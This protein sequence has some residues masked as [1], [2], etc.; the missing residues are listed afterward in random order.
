[1]TMQY[2]ESELRTRLEL[3]EDNGWEFKSVEFRG[4]QPSRDQRSTWAD[5]IVAFANAGGGVLLLGVT[6]EGTVPG[7]SRAQMDAVERIVGEI[8]RES[9][10]PE[11]HA[12]V[13]RTELDQS[14]FILVEIPEGYALHER[15]GRS[16]IR[17]GSAKRLMSPDDRM[18]LSQRRGQTRF[19][20]FDEQTVENTGFVTLVERL[21][22][23]LLSAES[24]SA[25]QVGL[26]KLGLLRTDEQG[27]TRATVAGVLLCTDE[28]DR[29]LPQATITAVCYRGTE[30]ASGQ[31]D[32]QE[33][34]G[35]IDRQIRNALA[36]ATR[37]MRVSARKMPAREDLPEYSRRAIF[38]ALVNAVAHRDYSIRGARIRLRMFSDRLELCSPGSLPNSLTVES[39]GERQS[40]RNEVLTSMLGRIDASGIDAA[41][42]RRFFLE[43][44]GDGV[45]IIRSE[46]LAL[47]GRP[48]AYRLIDGAELCLT[49]PAAEPESGPASVVVTVR[50][51]GT[52]LAGATVLALFPNNTWK[53]GSTNE[54]G[55]ARLDLHSVN[56][57]MTVFV[58]GPNAAAHVER[59]WLPSERPLAIELAALPDGGS[60]VF[61]EST[62]DV[63]GLTGR[64]NPILDTSNRTYLYAS[65]IAINGGQQQPVTF[66]PE[67]EELHLMD[68]NGRERLVRIVAIRGR[69]SLLE[70][71][72]VIAAA[73]NG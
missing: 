13:Y 56:L 2:N 25:P 70:Y 49:L 33:I 61:P 8:C 68:A 31:I 38:E 29:Y 44:R 43:R 30:P 20:S 63:P 26:E 69:S 5:E 3:G 41:S 45:P 52:P 60:I 50:K 12:R 48:A 22:K 71:R 57:P 27:R 21:W 66:A 42:G 16:Y 46:T 65:N 17:V 72:G 64:L 11:L 28:P 15:A 37:N 58:A 40:T 4:D 67:V 18:R 1:M 62:G 35:P 34:R 73:P 47:T 6:D 39:M 14:P 36:F 7:M 24:M 51:E 55:E 59:E 19:W 54:L 10:S 9:I 23:P 32:A 53:S